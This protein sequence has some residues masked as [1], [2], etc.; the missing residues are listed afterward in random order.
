MKTFIT[1]ILTVCLLTNPVMVYAQDDPP[2]ADLRISK[3]KKG[4]QAPY[5]GIL[6]TPDSLSKIESD[7]ELAIDL[8]KNEHK[9]EIMRLELQLETKETLRISEKKLH[10]EIFSSQVRRIESLEQIAINK[11]PEWVLPVAIL[12]SFLVGAG[13]TVGITYAVN[14]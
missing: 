4:Q 8:L 14:Q 7:N 1:T 6:L 9:Y 13:I 2:A 10:E 12:S 3:L 11:R 5:S